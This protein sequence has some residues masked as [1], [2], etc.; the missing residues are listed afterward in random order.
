MGVEYLTFDILLHAQPEQKVFNLE[1]YFLQFVLGA[2]G[3]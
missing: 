1:I 2:S 3:L